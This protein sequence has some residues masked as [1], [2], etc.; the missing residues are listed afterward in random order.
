VIIE[1]EDYVAYE[2]RAMTAN[3][4]S[5]YMANSKLFTLVTLV[6]MA[7][8]FFYVPWYLALLIAIAVQVASAFIRSLFM[9]K[10]GL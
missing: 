10:F 6:L 3:N 1:T 8:P 2:E 4:F 5:S 7:V 9:L